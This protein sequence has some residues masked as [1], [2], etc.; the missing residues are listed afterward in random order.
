VLGGTE[1]FGGILLVL[2]LFT[3]VAAA[4]IAFT[5]LV[6]IWKV[7][8]AQGFVGGYE[9]ELALFVIAVSLMLTGPGAYALDLPF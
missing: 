4:L 2:G 7:K 3:Q 6:A 1:F 5:M 9:F 8:R